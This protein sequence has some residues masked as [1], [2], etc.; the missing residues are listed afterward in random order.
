M[1]SCYHIHEESTT[2]TLLRGFIDYETAYC[3]PHNYGQSCTQGRFVV[4][5]DLIASKRR[6]RPVVAN[7]IYCDPLR[8]GPNEELLGAL[9]PA[10]HGRRIYCSRLESD[11][12]VLLLFIIS[13]T[14][15]Q[16]SAHRLFPMSSTSRHCTCATFAFKWVHISTRCRSFRGIFLRACNTVVLRALHSFHSR[17]KFFRYKVG[18]LSFGRRD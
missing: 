14:I 13:S 5:C 17:F 4:G 15:L 10:E 18:S 16:E 2:R 7:C 11:V 3:F 12:D 8:F 9:M 6:P 1:N